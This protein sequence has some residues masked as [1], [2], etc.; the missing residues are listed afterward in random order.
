MPLNFHHAASFF[1]SFFQF[2]GFVFEL[3]AENAGIQF[4][5]S[6]RHSRQLV[7]ATSICRPD[8]WVI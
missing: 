2:F 3:T 1:G 5:K 6:V 4:S 8:I 7:L